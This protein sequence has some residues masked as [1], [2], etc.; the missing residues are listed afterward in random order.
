[1]K[2]YQK[3]C[4]V[5][6]AGSLALTSVLL[7]GQ[8][9]KIPVQAVEKQKI[10]ILGDGISSGANLS[11]HQKSYADWLAYYTDAE[12]QNFSKDENTTGDI[13]QSLEDSQIQTA[14]SEADIII[15]TA[16][17]NDIMMPFF[18]TAN[19]YMEEFGFVRFQDI[20]SASLSAYGFATEDDLIPYANELA[21]A[22][23]KNKTSA[24]EN[25]KAITENLMQ[26][27][28]ATVLYQTVYNPTDTLENITSLSKKRQQAYKSVC[29]PV[30]SVM[31]TA[32]NDYL[33]E[34]EA[35]G[36]CLLA[37]IFS[38]FAGYAYLYTNLNDLNANPTAEGHIKIADAVIEAL[39]LEKKFP[40]EEPTETETTTST[41]TSTTTSTSASTTTT[42]TS[43]STTTST[44]TSTTTTST[45]TSTTTSTS[46]STTTTSTSTSTTTSTNPAKKVSV[47]DLNQDD[48]VDA[49]DAAVLLKTAANLGAGLP[50]GLSPELEKAAD[51]NQDDEINSADSA[52]ILVYSAGRGTGEITV[53]FS[54]YLKTLK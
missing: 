19:A 51:V 39:G 37:D 14:L 33:H 43:T 31:K 17:M 12:I 5:L 13:L 28:N 46:T 49:S 36:Q 50:S 45:S 29:N 41:S 3:L 54:E 7:Y 38:E 52:L 42:S 47:G 34:L 21:A 18:E 15:V 44:S 1:M 10:V 40:P 25:L 8:K 48:T 9:P 20:F 11:E 26:Y 2:F 27:Q 6:L 53:E 16:G 24:Q 32:F 23:R 30:T 35:D 22:A 4:S